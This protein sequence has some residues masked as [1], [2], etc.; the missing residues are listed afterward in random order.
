MERAAVWGFNSSNAILAGTAGPGAHKFSQRLVFDSCRTGHV[1]FEADRVVDRV[2]FPLSGIV[3]LIAPT[4]SGKQRE[5]CIVGREGLVGVDLALGIERFPFQAVCQTPVTVL[6]MAGADLKQALRMPGFRSVL[7]RYKEFRLLELVRNLT[8][9][10]L[11]EQR[12]AKWLLTAS[13]RLHT[14]TF[15]LTHA[16]TARLL[17]VR[18]PGVTET[19]HRFQAKGVIQYASSEVTILDHRG[20]ERLACDCYGRVRCELERFLRFTKGK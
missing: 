10:H 11:V 18:R 6:T 20:L 7:E 4:G 9:K 16:A 2:W 1:L 15:A 3:S 17:D 8:C 19:V 5:L 14:D 12:L 13:D